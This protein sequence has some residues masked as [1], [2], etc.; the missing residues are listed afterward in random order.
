MTSKVKDLNEE[1]LFWDNQRN[2]YKELIQSYKDRIAS[3]YEITKLKKNLETIEEKL[4]PI[5]HILKFNML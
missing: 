5:E 1:F 2:L 3:E 4:K